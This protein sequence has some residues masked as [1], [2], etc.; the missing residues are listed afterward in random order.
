MIASSFQK[1]VRF[2]FFFFVTYVLRTVCAF[3]CHNKRLDVA[4]P[5]KMSAASLLKTDE[6]DRLRRRHVYGGKALA[7]ANT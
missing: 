1:V 4:I 5:K 6:G 7:S 3:L 2:C